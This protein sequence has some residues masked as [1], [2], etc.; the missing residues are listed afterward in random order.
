MR[1]IGLDVHRDFCEI[2]ISDGGK[3]RSAG[4]VST[5]PEALTVLGNSLAARGQGDPREH[6]QRAGDRA[7]P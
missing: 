6:R 5:T 1:F 7:R 2:A 3:A 4:R